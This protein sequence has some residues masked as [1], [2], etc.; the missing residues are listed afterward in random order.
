MPDNCTVEKNTIDNAN[1]QGSFGICNSAITISAKQFVSDDLS[2]HGDNVTVREN[3]ISNSGDYSIAVNM[4]NN[5]VIIDNIISNGNCRS[6][7]DDDILIINSVA[8][9]R[10]NGG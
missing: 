5:A 3:H 7:K 4:Y 9:V 6:N 1:I 2:Y 8:D 10:D